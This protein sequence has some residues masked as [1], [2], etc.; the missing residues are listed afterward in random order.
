MNYKRNRFDSKGL[1][2]LHYNWIGKRQFSL[3]KKEKKPVK[4]AE[5]IYFFS[6]SQYPA[7][8]MHNILSVLN[9][10]QFSCV[11][12]STFVNLTCAS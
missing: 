5:I 9:T 12:K 8:S 4:P 6:F 10:I 11:G 7:L 3:Q 1:I 2:T